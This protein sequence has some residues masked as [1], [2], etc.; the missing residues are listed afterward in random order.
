M[1]KEKRKMGLFRR[2]EKEYTLGQI[3]NLMQKDT[4]GK[5]QDYIPVPTRPGSKNTTYWF[6]RQSLNRGLIYRTQIQL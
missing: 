4:E 2:R 3:L 5:Y 1:I 6:Q